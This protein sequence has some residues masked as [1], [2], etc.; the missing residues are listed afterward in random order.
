VGEAEDAGE[1]LR[2]VA[3][4]APDV[5]FLDIQLPGE[6]GLEAAKALSQ[7]KEPP[8]VVFV[9]GYE[10]YAVP[11][12]ELAAADYI[13]KPYSEERLG[14]TLE[15]VRSRIAGSNNRKVA[16]LPPLDRLAIRDR[17]GAK[18][19]PIDEICYISTQGRKIVVHTTSGKYSTHQTLTEMEQRLR[20]HRFF[21]AHEGCLV[22]LDK[23]QE[24]VYYGPRTYE[25]LLKE[26]KETFIPL[27]RSRTQK[28]REI[29]DF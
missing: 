19:I 22:N 25:L 2:R 10:Q 20:G 26:P 13:T 6:S 27:S 23:V 5:V 16:G 11:A 21:R 1:C 29:L 7:L 8:L 14:K 17:E 9:T 3:E 4:C 24:V 15:R 12:F 28:L 18:L